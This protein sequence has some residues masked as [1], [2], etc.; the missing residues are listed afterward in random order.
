MKKNI[1]IL[2]NL[3]FLSMPMLCWGQ[4]NVH[5]GKENK[6][7]ELDGIEINIYVPEQENRTDQ[8]NTK[9]IQSSLDLVSSKELKQYDGSDKKKK[10]PLPAKKKLEKPK[11]IP[12]DQF[13]QSSLNPP[14]ERR[15]F[16]PPQNSQAY[17]ANQPGRANTA[18]QTAPVKSRN[19]SSSSS[20]NSKNN[21]SALKNS[22]KNNGS[23]N[24]GSIPSQAGQDT[25]FVCGNGCGVPP[26]LPPNAELYDGPIPDDAIVYDYDCNDKKQP[27]KLR[28]K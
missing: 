13:M 10:E 4:N 14:G 15:V 7:V 3:S 1:L 9:K 12:A 26:D 21:S 2:L 18:N 6:P 23:G 8:K 28:S 11:L 19:I 17:N 24:G 25:I 27:Y 22:G 20:V 5:Y 16:Y